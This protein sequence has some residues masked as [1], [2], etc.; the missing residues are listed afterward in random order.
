MTAIPA[1]PTCH[2][3]TTSCFGEDSAPGLG[4]L[5]QLEKV[6]CDR[7]GTD[8][9]KSY[10]A[11][12]LAGPSHKAAQKVGEEGV[13]VALASLAEDDDA[14]AGEAADL[15]YHLMVVLRKRGLGLS[16]VIDV[17]RARHR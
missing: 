7:Q 11:K 15:I 1:G 2:T 13:E 4:F 3:G 17:L 16:D 9:A 6:I 5:A 12:L 14:L 10:T 8:P